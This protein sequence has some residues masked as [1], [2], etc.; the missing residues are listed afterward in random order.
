MRCRQRGQSVVEFGLAALLLTLLLFGIV[1]F[2]LLLNSWLRLSAATRDV[3]RAASLGAT[4]TQ[5]RQ[6]VEALVLPGVTRDPEYFTQHVRPCCLEGSV[7]PSPEPTAA[8][9]LDIKY[10]AGCMPGATCPP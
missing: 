7:W 2:G 4:Q 6:M 10:Y 1:D 9:V 3:A 5:L 8:V